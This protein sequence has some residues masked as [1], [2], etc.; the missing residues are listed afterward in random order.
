[1]KDVVF[2]LQPKP[3]THEDDK[4]LHEHQTTGTMVNVDLQGGDEGTIQALSHSTA[5]DA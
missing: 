2:D 1:V 4:A 3:T 5:P